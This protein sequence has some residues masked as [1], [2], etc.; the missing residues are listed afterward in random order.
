MDV[1]EEIYKTVETIVERYVANQNQ[2]E[3]VS[4]IVLNS[5]NGKYTVQVN[6]SKYVVK[7]GV[8]INPAPNTKVWVCIPNKDWN[9]AYICA[10]KGTPSGG[11][12]NVDDVYQN[13]NSVLGEDHIARINCA[14]PEDI[15]Q[16]QVNF[17]AGVDSIYDA[18]VTKGST[19]ES[20]ALS[21]VVDGI[22]NIETKGTLVEKNIT[23][24]GTYDAEDDNAD[25]YST[26][27]VECPTED[28]YG[29]VEPQLTNLSPISSG[30]THEILSIYYHLD[31]AT[32]P[33][34][35]S[36]LNFTTSNISSSATLTIHYTWDES[37]SSEN[38]T[39]TITTNGSQIVTV[40]YLLPQLSVGEHIFKMFVGI[41]GGDIV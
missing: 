33:R 36:T 9:K 6:G 32:R 8:G 4:G 1:K 7:D 34:F 5:I 11:Y 19:P 21:D 29:E 31:E 40:D 24:N 26:I 18:C 2:T 41:S 28:Y 20:H 22:L 17:Q 10:G 39:Q 3:Q 27:Y 15:Q 38:I 25:G 30:I 13:G 16:L 35:Y 14:T 12:G 37:G 23:R